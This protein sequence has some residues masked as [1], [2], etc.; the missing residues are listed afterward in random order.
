M[1]FIKTRNL[2]Y[3]LTLLLIAMPIFHSKRCDAIRDPKLLMDT[4]TNNMPIGA[5]GLTFKYK[6]VS[7]PLGFGGD[8]LMWGLRGY[9]GNR[10]KEAKLGVMASSGILNGNSLKLSIHM[11]GLTVE[12]GFHPDPRFNWRVS[13]GG[14]QYDFRSM[15]TLR[16]INKGFFTFIEP[17]LV[18]IH[19]VTR[20][21]I[22][23]FGIGYT[24][25]GAMGVR[26]EGIC[27][28]T[29]LLIGKF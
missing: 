2:Y 12:N 10:L 21:I 3:L 6:R 28:Q 22:L 5:G 18:G 23:E 1:N 29:E 25:C 20:H 7:G 8:M 4:P 24:F 15:Q 27:L 13:F 19:P 17:M 14:G 9:G 16:T 26:I 11:G